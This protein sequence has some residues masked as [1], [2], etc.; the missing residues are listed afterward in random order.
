MYVMFRR[1]DAKLIRSRDDCGKLPIH[2]ACRNKAPGEVLAL[3]VEQ[4][5]AT[6]HVTDYTGSHFLHDCCCRCP[7]KSEPQEQT[8]TISARRQYTLY[9]TVNLD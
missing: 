3:I 1:L 6:V 5:A 4:D 2:L 8:V 7:G 9:C